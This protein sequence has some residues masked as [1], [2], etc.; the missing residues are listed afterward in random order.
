MVVVN[1]VDTF[2]VCFEG[3]VRDRA[4]KRPDLYG[5]VQTGGRK[6]LRVLGIDGESHNVVSVPL[7][8][9]P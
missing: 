4:P 8:D 5:M 9:L 6:S 2:F 3:E 1:I 7:K